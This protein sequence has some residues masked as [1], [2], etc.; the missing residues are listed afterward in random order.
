MQTI[1]PTKA[2][3]I[4]AIMTYR[5]AG[6]IERFQDKLD[7]SISDATLLFDDVK[8]FLYLCAITEGH[9]APTKQI[10]EGWHHFILHTKDYAQF[11]ERHFGRMIHHTPFTREQR[12][13]SDGSGLTRTVA[14]ARRI[15]GDLSLNWSLNSSSDCRE[16]CQ[17]GCEN[18]TPISV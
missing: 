11:C 12:K 3:S 6:M 18:C 5:H 4:N 10:D 1:T 13:T 9:L 17:N 15:F 16:S 7:L 14:E 8:R 2:V